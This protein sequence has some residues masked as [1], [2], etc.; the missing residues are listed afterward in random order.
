MEA[1]SVATAHHM[2]VG[3]PMDTDESL[4]QFLE[5]EREK[6]AVNKHRTAIEAPVEDRWVFF[7]FFSK[8]FLISLIFHTLSQTKKIK[9]RK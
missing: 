1:G 5:K 7:T 4:R 3:Q 6:E 8:R 2:P 9:F